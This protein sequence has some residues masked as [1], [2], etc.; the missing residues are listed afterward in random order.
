MISIIQMTDHNGVALSPDFYKVIMPWRATGPLL[1]FINIATLKPLCDSCVAT[2]PCT[3]TSDDI[4]ST[5]KRN[6]QRHPQTSTSDMYWISAADKDTHS[7]LFLYLGSGGFDALLAAVASLYDTSG[8]HLTVYQ[9]TFLVVF[10]NNSKWFHIDYDPDL[11][12]HWTITTPI[13]L[14]PKLS[15]C[16]ELS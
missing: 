10:F 2:C 4:Q 11:A 15:P 14:V 6:L 7:S 9:V 16:C 12:G 1:D 8:F 13:V 3:F 5:K